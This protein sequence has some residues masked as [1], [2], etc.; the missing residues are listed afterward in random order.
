[1]RVRF[2]IAPVGGPGRSSWGARGLRRVGGVLDGHRL[3][4]LVGHAQDHAHGHRVH[5]RAG[6]FGRVLSALRS[7]RG[8]RT[9]STPSSPS[10]WC[11]R[12]RCAAFCCSCCSAATRVGAVVRRHRVP[13]R[14]SAGRRR[15]RVGGGGVPT[16]V[17][18]RARRLRGARPNMLDAARTLGW[19]TPRYSSGSCCRCRGRPSPPARCCRSRARWRVRCHAVFGRQLRGHHAYHPHR[20][21]L[22]VDERRT[23]VALFWTGVII[24]FS[25]VV[26]LFIN[27]WVGAP[28]GI[29]GGPMTRKG[30][31]IRAQRAARTPLSS[32][33][34]AQRGVEGSRAAQAECL[35]EGIAEMSQ[36]TYTSVLGV[37]VPRRVRGRGRDAGVFGR[38][39]LREEPYH[40]MHRGHRDAG[41]G[42]HRGERPGVLR[43][44]QRK[45]NLTPQQRKTALLFQSYMLFPNLT[46]AE[47]VAAG[48]GRG[49]RAA[50]RDAIVATRAQAL[51][52]GGLRHALSGAAL[53]RPAA[54]R[55]AGPHAGGAAR[56]P[57]AGRAVL[58][59]STRT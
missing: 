28:P 4:S 42:T 8:R 30:P 51:R 43:F 49:R 54:A 25:F 5:L 44:R 55:G 16:H 24:V 7:P 19:R 45:V 33:R 50:D 32:E 29:A 2:A 57:H 53:G 41:C 15:S 18:Q 11:C 3:P 9:S 26:I 14:Y 40:A 37:H 23:D 58:A 52:P 6:A 13:A 10:P 59:R 17:P 56:H 31:V 36:S 21:L 46:V 35:W 1:M 47:N 20:H 48:I 22:R 39:G 38:V 34:S 12:P 27:L